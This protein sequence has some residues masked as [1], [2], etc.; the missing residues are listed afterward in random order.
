MG[1]Q[2]FLDAVRE[3]DARLEAM[4][5]GYEGWTTGLVL[6]LVEAQQN[7]VASQLRSLGAAFLVVFA[8]IAVGLRSWRLTAVAVPP[9]VIPLLVVFAAMALFG[10]PLDAATVMVASVALGIAVDNTV[11]VLAAYQREH[12]PGE[13]ASDT[14]ARV[15]PR[16]APALVVTTATAAIGFASLGLS[17]FVPIRD[18]GLLAGAALVIALLATLQIVPALLGVVEAP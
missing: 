2:R 17:A 10:L 12:S 4:P 18:F 16:V 14:L 15:M 9:N 5:D 13:L 8:A 3:T 1:E 11:H 6:R 7:L